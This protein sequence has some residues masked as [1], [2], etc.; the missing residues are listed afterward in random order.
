VRILVLQHDPDAPA[1]LLAEW[2]QAREHELQVIAAPSLRGWPARGDADAIVSLGSEHSALDLSRHW[3][4]DEIEFLAAAHARSIPI[5]GICFGGQALSEALG[6][7]VSKASLAEVTW[8]VIDTRAPELITA[9]PWLFWHEDLFTLPPGA[10]LLAGRDAEVVAFAHGASIGI[11][12]HPEADAEIVHG[13][14][15][16][17]GDKLRSYGVDPAEFEREIER[18][19]PDA[20]E[21]AFDLF[22]RVA[23]WWSAVPVGGRSSLG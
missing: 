15:E 21:R 12:F 4:R 13:W 7:V 11:Q 16:G 23:R 17:A 14:I 20:R 2:A 5:L 8:R 18:H 9:G 3:I 19:G 1:G 10:R 6:G 22:D